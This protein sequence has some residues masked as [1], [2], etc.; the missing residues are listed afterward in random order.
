MTQGK[1]QGKLIVFE[2]IYGS[3]KIIVGLV[4]LV[5]AVLA[6]TGRPAAALRAG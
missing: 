2:G 1:V 4:E 3:G 6:V 5:R